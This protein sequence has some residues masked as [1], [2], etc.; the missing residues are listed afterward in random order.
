[1]PVAE[2]RTRQS[3]DLDIKFSLTASSRM[4]RIFGT[5]TYFVLLWL[6]AAVQLIPPAPTKE[7]DNSR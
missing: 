7:V 3:S 2:T 6:A 5:G 4:R 1:M